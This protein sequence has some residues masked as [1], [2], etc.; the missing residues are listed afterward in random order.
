MIEIGAEYESFRENVAYLIKK[1]KIK[2]IP[3]SDSGGLECY[4]CGNE[5]FGRAESVLLSDDRK[6][7]KNRLFL[8]PRCYGAAL[9]GEM[10]RLE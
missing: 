4:F 1:G 10:D 6:K 3:I 8:H 9:N 2:A 5:I 7:S